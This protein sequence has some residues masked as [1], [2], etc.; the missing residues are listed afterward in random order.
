MPD[1]LERILLEEWTRNSRQLSVL[2]VAGVGGWLAIILLVGPFFRPIWL[3]QGPLVGLYFV[4]AVAF[5][6][7]I[8]RWRPVPT[9]FRF[10]GSFLDLPFLFGAQ[11]IL[12]GWQA[13]AAVTQPATIFFLCFSAAVI[14]P[15][16]TSRHRSHI[17]VNVVTAATLFALLVDRAGL[18][19]VWIFTGAIYLAAIGALAFNVSDRIMSV[20]HRYA[21]AE[22]LGRYFS[23]AVADRIRAANTGAAASEKREVSLLFSDI[24]GFTAMS[25]KLPSEQ[26]VALLNEYLSI[27]VAIVF[28]HGGTL[29]KFMGDGL[30][31]YFGAPLAQPHHAVAAV[32]CG[33]DMLDAL[34][35][36]NAK[37]VAEGQPPL[38]IGIGIHS[39]PVIVGDIGPDQRREYTA[40]GDAVNLASRIEGLTKLKETPILVSDATQTLAAPAF[41]WEAAGSMA[42][43]GKTG[44]VTTFVPSRKA[45]RAA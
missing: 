15:A 42:V 18:S 43:R 31:A 16:P 19:P 25:E 29:D 22:R 44:D 8:T 1:A 45:E 40:I 9:W 2:R 26:V 33:L 39:G 23:P 20:A 17:V 6:L 21:D 35:V 12:V 32:N 13:S 11:Y 4:L 7:G 28:K 24:R 37:R 5:H 36:L 38:A 41:R 27:M 14:V 10:S 3:T 30:M 34:A